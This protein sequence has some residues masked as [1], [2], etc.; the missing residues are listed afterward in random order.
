M[1]DVRY[2][3]YKY[4]RFAEMLKHY[5]CEW[6][7][8]FAVTKTLM[9]NWLT[10]FTII[11]YYLNIKMTFAN[12]LPVIVIIS[13]S[14]YLKLYS[15]KKYLAIIEK[16]EEESMDDSV[17]GSLLVGFHFVMSYVLLFYVGSNFKT[18]QQ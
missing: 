15:K 10:V 18:P 7:A 2:F 9:I 3:Y 8:L 14:A 16:Y 1:F 4:Y 13:I 17:L 12:C 5:D 6:W 11:S